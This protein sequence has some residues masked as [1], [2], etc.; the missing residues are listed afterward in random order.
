MIQSKLEP[1]YSYSQKPNNMKLFIVQ[2]KHYDPS[3][4]FSSGNVSYLSVKARS[5]AEARHKI[6]RIKTRV[7]ISVAPY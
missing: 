6:N 2:N 4:G 3:I 1:I 7:V 5:E